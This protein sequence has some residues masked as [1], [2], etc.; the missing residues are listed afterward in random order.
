MKKIQVRIEDKELT[1]SNLE[2]I[3]WP[4]QGITKAELIKY[5]QEVSPYILPHLKDRPLTMNRFP[6]GIHGKNFYQKDCPDSAP[7]WVKTFPVQSSE[8]KTINYV[9]ADHAATIIWMANLGC[10]EMHPWLSTYQTPEF[11]SVMVFDL[12]PNEGTGL[13]EVLKIAPLIKAALDQFQVKGFAKTSGSSGLH[14]YVPLEP[15]YTF[16]E[17]QQ[18]AKTI[19]RAVCR[20][21][22]DIA[23]MERTVKKRGPRVYLD[24]LQ[25]ASGKTIASVYSLRPH[26][27]APVSF[28]V[29]WDLVEK[30][31]VHPLDYDIYRVPELLKKNGD[32]F[33]DTL[34]LRQNIDH[35]LKVK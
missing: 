5:Y 15:K 12:D 8:I 2:K 9:L 10:I 17:V 25:N 28:P 35:I 29:S 1:L 13:A 14:I 18:A 4:D 21:L 33:Q 22:P 27:K 30:G 34:N 26:P 24:C 3:L 32:M 16:K 20:L 23:T 6:D 31:Q 19:A 7:D 11:P